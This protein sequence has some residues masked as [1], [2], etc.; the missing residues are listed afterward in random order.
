MCAPV[1]VLVG[2]AL[3]LCSIRLDV[4]NVTYAV[5]DKVGRQFDGAVLYTSSCSVLYSAI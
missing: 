2:H 1:V 5:G 3:L 4:D